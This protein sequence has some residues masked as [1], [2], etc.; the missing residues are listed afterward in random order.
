MVKITDFESK[1]TVFGEECT[2][3]YLAVSELLLCNTE[4]SSMCFY[5]LHMNVRVFGCGD[6]SKGQFKEPKDIGEKP[7]DWGEERRVLEVSVQ[8]KWSDYNY[9]KYGYRTINKT[10]I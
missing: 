10:N 7:K 3:T 2:A 8:H 6:E 4:C 9:S 5:N 1:D